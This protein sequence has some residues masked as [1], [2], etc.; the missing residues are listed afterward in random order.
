MHLNQNKENLVSGILEKIIDKITGHIRL[1]KLEQKFRDMET[2]EAK[3]YRLWTE[4]IEEMEG[5]L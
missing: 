5:G 2:D 4:D 3:F 1:L